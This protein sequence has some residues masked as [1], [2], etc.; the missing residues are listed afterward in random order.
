MEHIGSTLNFAQRFK[1][2]SKY[3]PDFFRE[4]VPQLGSLEVDDKTIMQGA[5]LL[6]D[7]IKQEK[8]C[9]TCKGFE[10]CGKEGDA[11]GHYDYLDTY[12]GQLTIR[13]THCNQFLKF[14]ER[15]EIESLHEFAEKSLADRQFRFENYPMEQA[16][17]HPELYA[18]ALEIADGFRGIEQNYLGSTRDIAPMK[19]LYIFGPPG[20]GKTH[21]MLA[22][23]NRLDERNIPNIFV[24]ADTIFDKLRMN[25]SAG[26]DMEAIIEKYC[27]VPVLAIDEFAQERAN[28]F[29]LDKMFRIINYRFSNQ[30]PTLFTS[31]YEPPAV[32]RTFGEGTKTVDAM[33][34]RIIQMTRIGRLTGKDARLNHMEI[35]DGYSK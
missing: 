12:N 26:K 4:K 16:R 28:E 3:T 21:L 29:T 5:V 31:N 20:V 30:L 8:V 11:Q 33:I 14:V 13:T 24:R 19:G 9:G 34:S 7:L 23:C 2:Q 32:Y 22:I 1:E 10:Q 18:A 17:K 25:V 27:S 6:L 15:R 35:L